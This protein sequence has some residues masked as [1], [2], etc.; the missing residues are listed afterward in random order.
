MHLSHCAGR[1]TGLS[2]LRAHTPLLQGAGEEETHT[3]LL[4][5]CTSQTARDVKPGCQTSEPTPPAARSRLTKGVKFSWSPTPTSF[6]KKGKDAQINVLFP[7]L[8]TV[9]STIGCAHRKQGI[10]GQVFRLVNSLDDKTTKTDVTLRWTYFLSVETRKRVPDAGTVVESDTS[11]M[12][13]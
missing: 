9:V 1:E 5:T 11:A 10:D 2:D 7:V 4:S 12:E 3:A 13:L 6:R 8:L